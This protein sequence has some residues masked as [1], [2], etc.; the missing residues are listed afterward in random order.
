M[1]SLRLLLGVGLALVGL[2]D[3]A[4]FII[5]FLAQPKFIHVGRWR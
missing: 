1:K 3:L 5:A 2:C 4:A